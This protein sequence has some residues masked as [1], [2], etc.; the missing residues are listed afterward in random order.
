LTPEEAPPRRTAQADIYC[1]KESGRASP[2]V[3]LV[4]K[5][6]KEHVDFREPII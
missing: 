3:H 1:S 5:A 6:P 2:A 4:N